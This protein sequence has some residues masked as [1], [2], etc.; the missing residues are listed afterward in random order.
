MILAMAWTGFVLWI[1]YG[2]NSVYEYGNRI[3]GIRKLM[4][5]PEYDEFKRHDSELKYSDFM[6]ARHPNFFVK[7]FAC[8]FCFGV[9]VSLVFSVVFDC[10]WCVPV[11]YGSGVLAYLLFKWAAKALTNG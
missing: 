9:W 7:L 2:T 8:P 1:L 5:L 6:L 4:R 3:P 10:V 11:V